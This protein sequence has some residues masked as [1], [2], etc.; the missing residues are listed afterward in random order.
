MPTIRPAGSFIAPAFLRSGPPPFRLSFLL[1][2]IL[3]LV[4]ETQVSCPPPS[5]SPLPSPSSERK[6]SSPFPDRL[7]LHPLFV[8]R[9]RDVAILT[10]NR[11]FGRSSRW[12]LLHLRNPRGNSGILPFATL[13]TLVRT[14]GV[15]TWKRGDLVSEKRD[16]DSSA[17]II[18]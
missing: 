16:D 3:L 9:Q 14:M 5:P 12:R 15:D 1:L 7:P 10:P 4:H 13:A 2:C 11:P 8:A 17:K 6:S 18:A